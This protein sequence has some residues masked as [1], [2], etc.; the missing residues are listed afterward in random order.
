MNVSTELRRGRTCVFLM[1]VHLVFVTKY[2]RKVFTKQILNE[3]RVIFNNVCTD[4][5]AYLTEF[6][7]E[8]DHVHLLI[9]YPPKVAVSKLVN[10]LKGVS[11]RL[12][13]KKEHPSVRD[14]LWGNS[15]WSPSYFAGA[16]G[17]APLAV[18]QKYIEQ[19]Q[20]PQT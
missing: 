10:S 20:S 17:G 8:S 11:S 4:F 13:R 9:R 2:R 7:G 6:E 15:L 18:I 16:C 12:V 14:A 19:Q 5:E 3:L 1:H